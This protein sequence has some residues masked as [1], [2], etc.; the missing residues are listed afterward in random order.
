M[1]EIPVAGEHFVQ[2]GFTALRDPATGGF[3]PSVPLFI[4]VD[5]AQID[6]KTGL[7]E[8]ENELHI[9]I[10]TV[11]AEKF[12]AYVRGVRARPSRTTKAGGE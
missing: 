7:A 2:I 5:S 10:A 8:C 12:G 4:R 9:D 11:L 1:A 6:A 3:L